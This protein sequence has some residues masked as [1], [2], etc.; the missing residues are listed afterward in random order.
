MK[1][2]WLIALV[3]A[4]GL[5]ALIAGGFALFAPPDVLDAAVGLGDSRLWAML[6]GVFVLSA[7]IARVAF[8]RKRTA[9]DAVA[10]PAPPAP[11]E[12]GSHLR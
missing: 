11:V 2:S 12:G 4:A 7:V 6:G 9:E 3:A 8:V 1:R 10:D 5:T